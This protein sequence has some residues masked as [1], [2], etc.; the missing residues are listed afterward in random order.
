[1]LKFIAVFLTWTATLP[2]QPAKAS[3][4]GQFE[5]YEN[6][7]A[8]SLTNA[9]LYLAQAPKK[10][11][12]ANNDSETPSSPINVVLFCTPFT[13]HGVAT[14]SLRVAKRDGYP[15]EGVNWPDTRA[16]ITL[17]EGLKLVEGNLTW[18]GSIVGND[19]VE[20]KAKVRAIQNGEWRIKGYAEYI[21]DKNNWI[22]D[23]EQL[24]LLVTEN[25]V[26]ISKESFE[27]VSPCE[28]T[29]QHRIQ[30]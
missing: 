14:I 19:I 22:G 30:K 28:K 16:E 7:V 26:L 21:L 27:P 20:L 3:E 5:R 2:L 11:V 15:P 13:K 10:R 4:T 1:M 17:P 18:H 8:P 24:Y 25:R 9:H 23:E 6:I 12:V 29:R